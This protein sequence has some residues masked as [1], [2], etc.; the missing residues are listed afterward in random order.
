[1]SIFSN[2]RDKIFGSPEQNNPIDE[3]PQFIPTPSTEPPQ[4]SD[5]HVRMLERH[6]QVESKEDMIKFIENS[7]LDTD[8]KQCFTNIVSNMYDRNVIMANNDRPNGIEIAFLEAQL[9][10]FPMIL[11]S[12][13]KTDRA[14][15]EFIEIY[16]MILFQLRTRLSRTDTKDREGITSTKHTL[17]YET[18]IKR[19][20]EVK[21]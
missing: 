11:T 17:A 18:S 12:A 16:N 20:T 4:Y 7:S 15:P 14:S 2:I 21:K 19:Q 9:W 3:M 10:I 1:M 13:S 5:E 8:I 6:H